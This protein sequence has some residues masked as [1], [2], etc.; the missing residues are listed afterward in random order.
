LRISELGVISE[1]ITLVRVRTTIITFLSLRLD[2]SER[3]TRGTVSICKN[4]QRVGKLRSRHTRNVT[5]VHNHEPS[6]GFSR[7]DT[8]VQKMHARRL[9]IWLL[10]ANLVDNRQ[11]TDNRLAFSGLFR[12]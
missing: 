3:I 9:D 5:L 8:V 10:L 1:Q 6:L 4:L 12:Q 11:K 7:R 2:A